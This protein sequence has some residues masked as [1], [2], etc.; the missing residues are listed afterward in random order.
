MSGKRKVSVCRGHELAQ[1]CIYPDIYIYIP[2]YKEKPGEHC[3]MEQCGVAS[4]FDV[5]HMNTWLRTQ[6]FERAKLISRYFSP[7]REL[8]LIFFSRY[9]S[10]GDDGTTHV[11]YPSK[12]DGWNT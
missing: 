1:H 8:G 10:D 6:W 5:S 9:K 11:T 4:K 7:E 2:Q 12:V 3:F